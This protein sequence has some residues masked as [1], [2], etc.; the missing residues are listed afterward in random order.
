MKIFVQ[1]ISFVQQLLTKI[2]VPVREASAL[3]QISSLPITLS[4]TI[5]S[6]CTSRRM[7]HEVWSHQETGPGGYPISIAF[8]YS[9][10]YLLMLDKNH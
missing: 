8:Q 1:E 2:P 10:S 6:L 4:E 9:I 3:T 5:R 7:N